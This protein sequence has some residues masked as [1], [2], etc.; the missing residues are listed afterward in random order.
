M[1]AAHSTEE[2]TALL[3]LLQAAGPRAPRRRLLDTYDNARAVLAAG[4]TAWR[5]AGCTPVQIAALTAGNATPHARARAWL[6]R[7]GRHL[8]GWRD[9][10]YPPLLRDIARPPLALFVDGEP[11]L[12]QHPSIAVVGSRRPSAGGRD[13]AADFTHTFVQAGWVVVSGLAD[14]IDAAAHHAA[15]ALPGGLTVAVLGTGPD[16]AYPQH[17]RRLRER[18][19]SEGAVVSEYLPGTAPTQFHFPER[20]RIIAGL[21][22]GTVVI[23]AALRSGALITARLAAES[24]REAF[25]LPGSLHNPLAR[26]CHRLIRDGALLVEDPA[27]VLALLGPVA[28][29]RIGALSAA[30]TAP[31]DAART[32]PRPPPFPDNPDYQRLWQALGHDPTPM[33]SLIQRTGLTAATLSSMLLAM[34][35]EGSVAAQHGRYARNP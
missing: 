11:A 12:L 1:N 26:G 4:P 35:L 32:T 33:D 15:L 3:L 16:L 2:H 10:A 30:P 27:E 18:I 24:G 13:H 17:H 31:I 28:A 21:S 9:P 14:G 6:D 25:A 23:E 34:E 20:N 19:A 22:L 8:L 5:A 29:R 7:P